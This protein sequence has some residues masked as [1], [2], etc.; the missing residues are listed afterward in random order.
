LRNA[1]AGF[2]AWWIV[3]ALCWAA[4]GVAQPVGTQASVVAHSGSV[5]NKSPSIRLLKQQ[6]DLGSTCGGNPFTVNTSINVDT[7]AS[8]DVTLTAP[9]IG[10][11]EQFTDETGTNIGPFDGRFPNFKIPGFGGGLPPDTHI[12][13][14][15][16]TYTGTNL[17]G[18][19]STESS[20]TFDCTTGIVLQ[21]PPSR[22]AA[23]PSLS[24][25]ALIATAGFVLL[26]G[27]LAL[28]R[29]RQAR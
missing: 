1:G 24:P 16:T 29:V 17:S 10:L 8:A 28:K 27:A 6:S 2:K 11:L 7:S 26:L 19:V 13:L 25:F 5:S 21:Q 20:L 12:T 14:S 23:V 3:A 9:S 15:V 22:G 18:T 4:T